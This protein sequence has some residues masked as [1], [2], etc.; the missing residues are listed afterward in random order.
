M[1]CISERGHIGLVYVFCCLSMFVIILVLGQ[2]VQYVKFPCYSQM[3]NPV[4]WSV[5][6]LQARCVLSRR[7]LQNG[8]LGVHP[9]GGQIR[10]KSEGA[11]SG[12]LVGSKCKVHTCAGKVMVSVVCDSAWTSLVEFLERCATINSDHTASHTVEDKF[13]PNLRRENLRSQRKFTFKFARIAF[14]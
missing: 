2:T 8:I 5:G 6:T 1:V 9:S 14:C 3:M 7:R 13:L 4:P 12:L 10:W 11:K